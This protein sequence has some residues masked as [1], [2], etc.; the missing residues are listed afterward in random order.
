VVLPHALIISSIK[1]AVAFCKATAFDEK[2]FSS[3]LRR[4]LVTPKL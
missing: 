4:R 1:K 3:Y 2:D